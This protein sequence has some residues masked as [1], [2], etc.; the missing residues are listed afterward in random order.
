MLSALPAAAFN[1][2]LDETSSRLSGDPDILHNDPEEKDIVVADL[3]KDGD[4][5]VIV[6][7]KVPFSIAGIREDILLMNENAVLVDRTADLAPAMQNGT[8]ARE[9]QAV[10]LDGDTWLDVVVVNTFDQHPVVLMN[11]GETGG[12][13]NGLVDES[14]RIPTF[15]IP[16]MFCGLGVGDVT[17]NG[18]P[19]LYFVD[20]ENSL[21]DRLLIND[22][23][24]FFTDETN[25][26]I[27]S[28]LPDNIFGTGGVILDANMDGWQ[29]IIV[30]H[31]LEDVHILYND[32]T[33]NFPSEHILNTDSAYM[34]D[35]A[36]ID[37][38]GRPDLYVIQDGQDKVLLNQSTQPNG[39]VS[40]ASWTLQ[41]SSRTGS[42]GGNVDFGDVDNDSDLDIFVCD[43]DIDIGGCDREATL[44]E[45]PGDGHY[46]DPQGPDLQ[47]HTST[48]DARLIDVDDDGWLDIY[49][50][51]CVGTYLLRQN[52][53]VTGIDT[54]A[55]AAPATVL[56]RSR[57]NPF[58][59]STVIEYQI[60][61]GAVTGATA[62]LGIY[63]VQGRLVR[64]WVDR[65]ASPGTHRTAWDGLDERGERVSPGT[66]FYRLTAGGRS[67]RDKLAVLE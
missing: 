29:D 18:A 58:K 54:P 37:G 65:P 52:G 1:E 24:G 27:G 35:C 14:T 30:D 20:Y 55:A 57:P 22:G 33:G 3:D 11:Q 40:F 45:N 16:P 66:Y 5:D 21:E 4:D 59:A 62:V 44:L 41:Q 25:T 47:M 15:P 23:N 39:N 13:W 36:D 38:N 7:R 60:G 19:D 48:F 42:F 8:D 32:Q 56:H 12:T 10:D 53:P 67:Y 2:F 49:M 50:G 6:V 34:F 51:L 43:I 63:D 9:V 46:F 64:Q 31:A 17:G 26:R 61:S 28:G